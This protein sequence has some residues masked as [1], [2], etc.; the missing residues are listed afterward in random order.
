[1]EQALD[2]SRRGNWDAVGNAL[3]GLRGAAG[4]FDEG[5]FTRAALAAENAIQTARYDELPELLAEAG[6]HYQTV[7]VRID[8]WLA[9]HAATTPVVPAQPCPASKS[10]LE[11]LI[12]LV[13]EQAF[14]ALEEFAR[15]QT[16]LAMQAPTETGL[17]AKLL[18]ELD[19]QQAATLLRR[20]LAQ[21]PQA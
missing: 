11:R 4:R 21:S 13:E 19:F 9:E 17:V 18:D 14:L 2:A 3:H 7:L 10:E 5:E 6:F 16:T 20:V 1:M 8:N 12:S 15:M